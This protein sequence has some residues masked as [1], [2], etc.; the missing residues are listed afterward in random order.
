MTEQEAREPNLGAVVGGCRLIRVIGRGGMG[1]VYLA[2][3]EALSRQVAVK[4]IS[5]EFADDPAFRRRF[6]RE[7]RLAAAIE[8]P[9][10]VPVHAAGEDDGQLFIVMRF[11]AGTDLRAVLAEEG[12]LPPARAVEIV[13]E[14]AAG[15]D[16][17]HAA[18]L[19]H[20]DVKPANVLLATEADRPAAYLTDFGLTKE[21]SSQ[22]GITTSG[23]WVGTVDYIAPEQLEHGRVDRRADVYALGCVLYEM[24]AGATPYSGTTIQKMWAHV[25]VPA[26]SL[27]DAAPAGATLDPVVQKAMAKTPAD[28][29]QSAGAF[30]A[31]AAAV[32]AG[33]APDKAVA[34]ADARTRVLAG[35]PPAARSR[36]WF[37]RAAPA[38]AAVAVAAAVALLLVVVLSGGVDDAEPGRTDVGTRVVGTNGDDSLVAGPAADRVEGL[39]GDDE[40]DGGGGR[41]S[42]VAGAG[43]HV[44]Q[45]SD[46]NAV[47]AIACGPGRDLVA[48]PD[49][50]D[51]LEPDCETAGWTITAEGPYKDRMR[52]VP[53]AKRRRV[54]VEAR[55]H[56]RCEGSLELRTPVE[57][58]LLA[59]GAFAL[60]R[61]RWRSVTATLNDFGLDYLRERRRV[62][63]VKR[64]RRDCRCPNPPPFVNSGFTTRLDYQPPSRNR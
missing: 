56:A 51:V 13:S 26:P 32:V 20:R 5:S 24:I 34:A 48:Q 11:I 64:G 6:E 35:S 14:V 39:G 49:A 28:R 60:D 31:A 18:G 38:L 59:I 41:D 44:I 16:A 30:A 7:S 29:F 40:I 3:Q 43:D 23:Q 9:N 8:H 55:C 50:R 25:N 62:R 45:A 63:V 33:R 17:A 53:R 36:A 42:L 12:A 1:V 61:G 19:V 21:V 2:E 47:D 46:D 22:S 10:L 4:V 54:T 27:A 58:R 37:R 15:L 57:R 52:V